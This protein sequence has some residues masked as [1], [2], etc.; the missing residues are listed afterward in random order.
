MSCG[1][2]HESLAGHAAG[3]PLDPA[4]AAHLA[5]C[6]ACADRLD[7]QRRLLAEVDAE[8]ARALSVEASPDFVAQ[9]AARVAA[10]PEQRGGWRPTVAWAGLAAA[11]AL[12]LG[13]YLRAPGP[14]PSVQPRGLAST[15]ASASPMTTARPA[16]DR[17]IAAP[18]RRE[19][20]RRPAP[21]ASKQVVTR[22]PEE[23]PEKALPA[24]RPED[25][26]VL[27]ITPIEI[28]DIP[29]RDADA[30]AASASRPDG[31]Q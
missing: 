30:G 4:A 18:V 10:P 8:L 12:A 2:F 5:A 9:V 3:A 27:T 17:P 31:R 11:A 7:G 16:A 14:T 21:H 13:L 22:P 29:V 20:A 1:R 23:P 19:A 15:G 24:P 26:A 25:V 28:P 6:D